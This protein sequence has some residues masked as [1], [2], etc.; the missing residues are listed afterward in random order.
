MEQKPNSNRK[1]RKHLSSL[2]AV[3][4][5]PTPSLDPESPDDSIA[6]RIRHIHLHC[7][8]WS[9]NWG[10]ANLWESEFDRLL[11][12]ARN[13]STVDVDQF[14]EELSLH[15]CK[16][17]QAC[18]HDCMSNVHGNGV[19]RRSFHCM[20]YYL[21]IA[22]YRCSCAAFFHYF[23]QC[24]CLASSQLVYAIHLRG[25]CLVPLLVSGTVT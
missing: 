7:L 15:A 10:P 8:N 23:H 11:Q 9:Y 5:D 2:P 17:R 6:V 21:P 4:S 12:E 25:C 3:L 19:P 16:G 1:R 18:D 13:I 24:Y 20:L 22:T 14:F